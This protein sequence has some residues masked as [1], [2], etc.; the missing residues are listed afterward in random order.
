M[1]LLVILTK[2]AVYGAMAVTLLLA[3][4]T[5]VLRNLFHAAL[6]LA[7]VL[8]G[9]AVLY[10]VMGAEFLAMIQILI[11]VGA[12]ITLIIFT[13]MLTEKLSDKSIPQT[14]RQ[15]PAAAV[16]LVL[17]GIL[18]SGVLLKTAWPVK[19]AALDKGLDLETLAEGLMTRYVFP[20]E[21]IA[22][23]LFAVLIGAVAVARKDQT[24]C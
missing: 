1:D 5:V 10:I 6:C 11:Y 22:L 3:L 15:S 8:I 18:L 21:I 14:N 13:I 19:E 4:G 17:L 9:V 23:L 24:P 2:I 7:A 20:F 12:V 16:T